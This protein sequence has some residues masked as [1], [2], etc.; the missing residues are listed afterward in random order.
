MKRIRLSTLMLLVVIAAVCT[1]LI[2]LYDRAWRREAE[3]RA[4]LAEK[5]AIVNW[6]RAYDAE[7]K[8]RLAYWARRSGGRGA[9][10][11]ATGNNEGKRDEP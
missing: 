5:D 11:G 2:V 6:Y 1:A 8:E 10:D 3:L 9:A 4:R 7:L